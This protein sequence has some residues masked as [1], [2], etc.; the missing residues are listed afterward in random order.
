M[1]LLCGAELRNPT[2]RGNIF[3]QEALFLCLERVENVT[4][5]RPNLSSCRQA[6]CKLSVDKSCHLVKG[7]VRLASHPKAAEK[8]GRGGGH[9][10]VLSL[11]AG[12][13]VG[14]LSTEFDEVP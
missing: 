9:V 8:T 3:L 14:R 7:R 1:I 2:W 10:C 5:Q 4:R 13:V 6:A 12:G 11:D